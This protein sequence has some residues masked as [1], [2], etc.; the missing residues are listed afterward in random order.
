LNKQ[1]ILIIDYGTGNI[2]SIKN[3]ILFNDGKVIISSKTEEI[4]SA[5]HIILPGVG[6]FPEAIKKL[7][8]KNLIE[9]IQSAHK[10][11][12]YILGICLG[13]QLFFTEGE[14]FVKCKGL[15]LIKG[16]IKKMRSNL[17][18]PNIG[19]RN[20]NIKEKVSDIK[21]LKDI[22]NKDNFYFIHSYILTEYSKK[23]FIETSTYGNINF[24]SVFQS[25]NIFGC[26]FHPE[27]SRGAGLKIIKNFINLK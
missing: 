20:C 10:K 11:G 17:K 7:K 6:S 12:A 1:K 23:I 24:P 16:K 2:S 25:E 14:E 18:L 21:I 22:T 26:Q 4:E 5:T 8:K 15:D 27:K 9:S 13:M 3:A 19:W